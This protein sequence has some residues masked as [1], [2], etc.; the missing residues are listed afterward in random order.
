MDNEL[1]TKLYSLLNNKNISA[2][3]RKSQLA[4]QLAELSVKEKKS[5]YAQL[6]EKKKR[7]Q[8]FK[9][10]S[11]CIEDQKNKYILMEIQNSR[12]EYEQ[13]LAFVQVATYLQNHLSRISFET[14]EQRKGAEYFMERMFSCNS[15]NHI[16][17]IYDV[18][19]KNKT[20]NNPAYIPDLAKDA[21]QNAKLPGK[22][23]IV[24]ENGKKYICKYKSSYDEEDTSI[25]TYEKLLVPLPAFE[26]FAN[27]KRYCDSKLE[28][29]RMLVK[30]LFGRIPDTE[31]MVHC[32]GLFEDGDQI[33]NYRI[34]NV[35]AFEDYAFA[36]PV[37]E[38]VIIDMFKEVKEGV[39]LYDAADPN[40]ELMCQGRQ[41][42]SRA[43]S[44]LIKKKMRS[45]KEAGKV[46]EDSLEQIRKYKRAQENMSKRKDEIRKIKDEE[47]RNEKLAEIEE[48]E[49]EIDQAINE[50]YG[51][52]LEEDEVVVETHKFRGKGKKSIRKDLLAKVANL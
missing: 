40:I 18:Y 25:K 47:E 37:G 49:F 48:C 3:D 12:R 31:Y 26:Q 32:H 34:T 6:R 10:K 45:M 33:N 2:K 52:Y 50:E 1:F 39:C 7:K 20:H 14:E 13:M 4:E 23:G 44:K 9:P 28:E 17:A 43:E 35:D 41:F 21:I 24:T 38:P 8:P 30:Y 22:V 27:A 46:P 5:F 29:S 42:V 51:N 19:L 15:D 36:V 16:G 11:M